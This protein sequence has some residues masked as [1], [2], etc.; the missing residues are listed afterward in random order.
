M[1]STGFTRLLFYSNFFYVFCLFSL[2][3]Q[4]SIVEHL[5]PQPRLFLLLC[6]AT[7]LFYTHAYLSSAPTASAE[8]ER[9]RWYQ[10]NRPNLLIYRNIL[11]FLLF[12]TAFPLLPALFQ[13][14][15]STSPLS[16]WPCWFFPLLALLYYGGIQPGHSN[17]N[18]RQYGWLKPMIIALVWS[19]TTVLFPLWWL[20]PTD[21]V[22]LINASTLL[23]FFQSTLFLIAISIL[24]DI[25]DFDADHNQQ[26]KTWAIRVG[27]ENLLIRLILP[28]SILGCL[29]ELFPL[30]Q[31]GYPPTAALLNCFPWVL[32]IFACRLLNRNT[33]VLHYLWMIDGL[34]P[35]KAFFG[36]SAHLLTH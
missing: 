17:L 8:D 27:T 25:K 24:F 4:I 18:L 21:K 12:L 16:S 28:I 5:P 30:L 1:R 33:P 11:I 22:F 35:V 15:L 9:I 19:G 31:T 10:Q 2:L 32:L 13:R 26:L 3:L 29:L 6:L 20:H 34:I 7:L 36:I 23:S 14:L